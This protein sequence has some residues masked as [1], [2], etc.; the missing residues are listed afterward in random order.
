[1]GE[2]A[3]GRINR[4][5]VNAIY[6]QSDLEGRLDPEIP[7]SDKIPSFDGQITVKSDDSD[8]KDVI[9]NAVPTQV[10]GTVVEEFTRGNRKFDVELADCR[11]F[12][13]RGGCLFFAV[14]VKG[15]NKDTKIFYKQLLPMELKGIID[16]KGHQ[17]TFRI[18]LRPLEETTLYAVC[19]TFLKHMNKQ[20][21][22]LIERN[23]YKYYEYEKIR[24][25]SPTFNPAKNSI[26]DIFDHDFFM[27]GLK[28]NI[29]FPI[30]T[31][32]LQQ[33]E[34]GEKSVINVNGRIFEM[35]VKE[36]ITPSPEEK[37][38]IEDSLQFIFNPETSGITWSIKKI[39]SLAVHLKILDLLIEFLNC[40]KIEFFGYCYIIPEYKENEDKMK[41]YI[42]N[43]KKAYS[44][45]LDLRKVFK[46]LRVDE[47]IEFGNEDLRNIELRT[48]QI[49][50]LILNQNFSNVKMDDMSDARF[51]NHN[52][53][54]ISLLL[55]YSPNSEPKLINAFS[56]E[57]LKK[58]TRLYVDNLKEP[59]IISPI[60]PYIL[61]TKEQMIKTKNIDF[62]MI[63]KSFEP[64]DCGE[65]ELFNYVNE[66]CLACLN[67]YDDTNNKEFLRLTLYLLNKCKQETNDVV[68]KQILSIN[69]FQAKYRMN[70]ELSEKE[71]TE[72]FNLRDNVSSLEMK[73]CISV[74]LQHKLE[75]DILFKGFNADLKQYYNRLPIYFLYSELKTE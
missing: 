73:F 28:D 6:S 38:I 69:I 12:Y 17:G 36:E 33:I 23:R 47:N 29:E 15:D 31:T 13:K 19:I 49:N 48:K 27:Y 2:F 18:E 46:E 41:E 20:T 71:Y 30:R 72:L 55:F 60:S 21:I 50:E 64:M 40:G 54:E 1:M 75:A 74:L 66:L 32:R 68:T 57:V 37:Y 67:V 42:K 8:R 7:I 56:E 34:L 52:I 24:F 61:L 22:N 35:M 58:T 59:K 9:L 25:D 39:K 44:L 62:D 70:G 16:S 5:A 26:K 43:F 4:M 53:G 11:N 45:F 10:K 51:L 3:Q 63:I 14:E 65:P